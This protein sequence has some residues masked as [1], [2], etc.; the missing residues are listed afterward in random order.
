MANIL[1]A[2]DYTVT[3]RLLGYI[4]Q[5]GGHI[6][7]SAYDGADALVKLHSHD[8][9]LMIIDIAMPKMDGLTLLR[10][11]RADKRYMSLPVIM[12]TASGEDRHRRDAMAEGANIYLTKPVSSTELS[13]VVNNILK[14]S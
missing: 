10:H 14:V 8:F 11:I 9:D 1:V 2:E 4:L 6:V 3:Q 13:S 12:L 5:V 7:T